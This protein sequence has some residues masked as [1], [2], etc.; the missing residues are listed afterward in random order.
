MPVKML[1][2]DNF[3]T[4]QQVF[5]RLRRKAGCRYPL[6]DILLNACAEESLRIIYELWREQKTVTIKLQGKRLPHSCPHC[7]RRDIYPAHQFCAGCG[8][9]IEWV[10]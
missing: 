5:Q 2:A 6:I 10:G 1:T 7:K 3:P 4:Q 8:R 9:G